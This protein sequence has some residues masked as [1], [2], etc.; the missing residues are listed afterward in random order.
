[1]IRS[2][3]SERLKLRKSWLVRLSFA[4]GLLMPLL[5]LCMVVFSQQA[6]DSELSMFFLIVRQNHI[7]LT[8]MIGNLLFSLMTANL[9]Y[10]EFQYGTIADIISVPVKR[11]EYILA[12]EFIL[13]V[14][15][16]AIGLFSYGVCVLIG[17]VSGM[18]GF[19]GSMVLSGLW[20]YAL[21]TLLSFIPLQIIVW[22]TVAF[23]NYVVS[24]GISIIA[25]V[26]AIVA[27]NTTDFIFVYPFSIA[28]VLTNFHKAITPDQVMVGA[29]ALAVILLICFSGTLISFKRMDI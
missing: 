10:R 20:R 21:A 15:I 8:I 11:W 7:F 24:L 28:F 16:M 2:I 4:I 12:K 17:A 19:T 25:L 14:W 23:K 22:A 1:M 27:F 5:T 29:I 13:L 9:F 6:R 26:G 3:R 18:D